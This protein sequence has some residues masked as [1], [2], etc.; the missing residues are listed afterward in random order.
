VVKMTVI[1]LENQ[2]RQRLQAV[3]T[4]CGGEYLNNELKDFY[5]ARGIMHETTA[6]YTPEQN[7]KAERLNRTLMDRV[8][9]M[10]QGAN[11]MIRF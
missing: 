7:G 10:L 6:P 2:S 3:R 9:A 1:L 5:A 8:R 4:D 11:L